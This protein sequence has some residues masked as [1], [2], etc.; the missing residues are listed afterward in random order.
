[1]CEP[2]LSFTSLQ[3]CELQSLRNHA[4]GVGVS[5]VHRSITAS[6]TMLRAICFGL[7]K[8]RSGAKET[9][10]GS[11]CSCAVVCGYGARGKAIHSFEKE[12]KLFI[13]GWCKGEKRGLKRKKYR[14]KY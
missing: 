6:K 8:G 2:F 7:F 13:E 5:K 1:M 11:E 4:A 3:I 10:R 9:I 14:K 12:S